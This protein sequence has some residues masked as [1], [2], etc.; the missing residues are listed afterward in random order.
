M[1]RPYLQNFKIYVCNHVQ[2]WMYLLWNIKK[3]LHK[4][5]D[6]FACEGILSGCFTP[7]L[8]T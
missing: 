1:K 7:N 8:Q 3:Y 4:Y 2:V 6:I 5:S